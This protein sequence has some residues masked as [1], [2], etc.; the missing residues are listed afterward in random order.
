VVDV[1]HPAGPPPAQLRR[2]D[3]HEAGQHHGV[4][5]AGVDDVGEP[6][7][8]LRLAIGVAG[9]E[10]HVV[11]GHAVRSDDVAEPVVVADDGGQPD[12]QLPG[13][14]PAQQVVQAVRLPADQ[15][16][17]PLGH[18]GVGHRPPG[19]VAAQLGGDGGEPPAQLRDVVGQRG[20][21]HDLPGEE[22]AGLRV[23]VVA[24]LGDPTAV[25]GQERRDA[26]DDPG[27]VGAAQGEY[28]AAF[29]GG[30]HDMIV[31]PRAGRALCTSTRRGVQFSRFAARSTPG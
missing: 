19:G 4:R 23:G 24:G 15:Q 13:R 17:R 31:S 5:V 2:Q 6:G 11:E 21:A 27:G 29:G 18:A 1:E 7:E 26:G 9:G 30:V 12:G 25:G 14:D 10:R 20:R 3:L 22:P 8:G 16:H 28:V